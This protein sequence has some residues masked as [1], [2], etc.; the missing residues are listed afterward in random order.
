MM[1]TLRVRSK[2]LAGVAAL[3]PAFAWASPPGTFSFSTGSPDG[4]IGTASRPDTSGKVEIESADDFVLSQQTK[5]T[6]ASF[7]G[8]LTGGGQVQA[9]NLE[10]YRVFPLDSD[11]TRTIQVPTRTNSPSDAEFVSR[12]SGGTDLSF[13]TAVLSPSFT[14]ANS[15]LNGI[16]P[17]PNFHT[18]GEGAVQGQETR[19]DVA[20][21]NAFDLPAG[22]YFFV[23][24]VQTDKGDFYWLSAPKPISGGTGPFTPDL[25]SWIRNEA[26]APDWLRVGTDIVGDS[27]Y[28]ASFSL[29]GETVAAV[30]EPATALYLT[31]GLALLLGLRRRRASRPNASR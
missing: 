10:I 16:H 3:M 18:G 1:K 7:T 17:L 25:Q 9:L 5:I 19:V 20:L 29:A 30:P 13:S 12:A 24:Q 27:A 2:L 11:A 6:S 21:S 23:P 26:L 8:L 14:A 28:N 4:L 15:V 31:G 22:H